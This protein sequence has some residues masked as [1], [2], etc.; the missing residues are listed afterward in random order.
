MAGGAVAPRV[1]S[2][3]EEE[4]EMTAMLPELASVHLCETERELVVRVDM[5]PEV[6]LSRVAAH[7][8]HGVLEITLPRVAQPHHIPGFHPEVPGV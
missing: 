7:L 6:D 5:P 8:V 2:N 4:K 3:E 1:E